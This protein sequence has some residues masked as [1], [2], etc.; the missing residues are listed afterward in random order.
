VV[1]TQREERIS[2]RVEMLSNTKQEQEKK[3]RF[4]MITQREERLSSRVEMQSNTE[5]KTKQKNS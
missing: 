5:Q 3:S 1:I 2:S 4:F